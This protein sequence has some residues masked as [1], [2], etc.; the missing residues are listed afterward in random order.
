VLRVHPVHKVGFVVAAT[1]GSAATVTAAVM[2]KALPDLLAIQMPKLLC[3]SQALQRDLSAYMGRY[4]NAVLT[5][6]VGR[7]AATLDMRAYVGSKR[8][9]DVQQICTVRLVPARDD[10][11]F[12]SPAQPGF[13]SFVQFLRPRATAFEYLWNGNNILPRCGPSP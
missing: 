6:D 2:G 12:L 9:C 3:E 4:R 5:L 1:G 13:I 11:F 8:A 7:S 10:T